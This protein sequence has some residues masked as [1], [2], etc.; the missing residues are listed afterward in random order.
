[1]I[2]DAFGHRNFIKRFDLATRELLEPLS[3]ANNCF[4]E[5][6]V[7]PGITIALLPDVSLSVRHSLSN[8]S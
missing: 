3:P 1:M 5:G 4:D 6:G 8:F 7:G 2:R